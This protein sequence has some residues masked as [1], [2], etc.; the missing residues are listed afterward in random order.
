MKFAPIAALALVIMTTA[1]GTS[2][3]PTSLTGSSSKSATALGADPTTKQEFIKEVA[4]RGLKLT[5]AQLAVIAAGRSVQPSGVF[6]ERPAH[7]LTAEQNLDIHF[8]KHGHEFK[9]AI[10]SAPE[11]LQHAMD[12]ASGKRG[13]LTFYFDTQSFSKGYQSNVVRWNQQTKEMTALRP[14]GA[15]TTLYLNFKLASKRFVVVP[16]F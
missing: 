5:D 10:S 11:Y 8:K 3:S 1:C 9:P 12:L 2:L 4:A 16:Q 13:T 7:K 15:V 6:A 14:D